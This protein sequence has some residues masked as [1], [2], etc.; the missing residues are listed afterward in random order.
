MEMLWQRDMRGTHPKKKTKVHVFVEHVEDP[1]WKL[2]INFF[3]VDKMGKSE[4]IK[5]PETL[6]DT[7][8]ESE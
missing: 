7:S 8:K 2:P 5:I 6:A 1:D 3:F 4:S